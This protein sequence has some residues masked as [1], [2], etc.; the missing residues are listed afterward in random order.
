MFSPNST[1]EDLEQT[2]VW[3]RV[4]SMVPP[5]WDP[6]I[7]QYIVDMDMH[8]KQDC[9]VI[10]SCTSFLQITGDIGSREASKRGS[11]SEVLPVQAVSTSEL[12]EEV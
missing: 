5:T 3:C 7:E 11:E 10:P 1:Q 6:L 8:A 9:V 12:T 2:E 4:G